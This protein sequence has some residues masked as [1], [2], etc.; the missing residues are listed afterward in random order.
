MTWLTSSAQRRR[1]PNPRG[2][3]RFIV[4]KISSERGRCF[5]RFI[6]DLE[7]T[8][9]VHKCTAQISW[10]L[11]VDFKIPIF[12]QLFPDHSSYS[13][14]L[15]WLRYIFSSLT[16]IDLFYCRAV[17]QPCLETALPAALHGGFSGWTYVLRLRLQHVVP[18]KRAA[19]EQTA[20]PDPVGISGARRFAAAFSTRVVRCWGKCIP[21]CSWLDTSGQRL[22]CPG[23]RIL[24]AGLVEF[25]KSKTPE[26][27]LC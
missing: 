17:V 1:H 21:W 13:F 23:N 18:C 16:L 25:S 7:P 6:A 24:S 10:A 4:G 20:L 5:F 22:M 9:G 14:V 11:Q 2:H 26:W 15:A 3:L 19:V 12:L 8:C 27:G